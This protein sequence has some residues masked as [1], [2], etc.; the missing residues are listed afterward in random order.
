VSLVVCDIGGS[1]VVVNIGQQ[2]FSEQMV[3]TNTENELEVFDMSVV[4][5]VA[6][7]YLNL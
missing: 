1:A 2:Q 5:C 3:D 4:T 7:N 6:I